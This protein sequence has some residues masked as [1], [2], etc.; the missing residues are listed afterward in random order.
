LLLSLFHWSSVRY[1][2]AKRVHALYV[3]MPTAL[4]GLYSN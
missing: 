1:E 2:C 3:A 4:V